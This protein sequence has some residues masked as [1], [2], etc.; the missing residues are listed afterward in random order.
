MALQEVVAICY[1]DYEREWILRTDA[2]AFGVGAALL[3][4]YEP[5]EG[6]PPIYQ[7]LGFFSQKFSPQAVRW[8]TIEQEP[9]GIYPPS[10]TSGITSTASHSSS[11]P[12]TTISSSWRSRLSRRL[13][14]GSS[15]SFS[16]SGTSR[17]SSTL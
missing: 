14:D 9:Y 8:S 3:Q 13:S 2:S 1:P 12:T 10:T 7:P 4:V 15:L 16:S 11:R 6:S 5:G 17:A